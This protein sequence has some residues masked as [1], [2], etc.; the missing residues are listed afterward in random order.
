MN[1][2]KSARISNEVQ[3]DIDNVVDDNDADNNECDQDF[4]ISLKVN[5]TKIQCDDEY[6][7]ASVEVLDQII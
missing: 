7:K 6:H 5:D 3:S 4:S 2:D 1:C